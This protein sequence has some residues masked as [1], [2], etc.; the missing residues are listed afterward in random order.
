MRRALPGLSLVVASAALIAAQA[1]APAKTENFVALFN[2]ATAAYNARDYR[3]MQ[4]RL[5]EALA[6]R[7]AHPTALYNLASAQ[8]LGG[9]AA[10]ALDTLGALANMGLTFDPTRDADFKAL[11]ADARFA[12]VNARF[13]RN[14]EP[15]GTA[16]ALFRVFT[17]TFIPEGIA[18]DSD[19]GA[20]FLG[21]AHER[22]IVRIPRG[23]QDSQDFVTPGAGGLWAPLGMQADP[24]RRLLW[25]ATASIPEMSNAD[26]GEL[27]RS[28]VLAYDL[29]SGLLKRRH[30][31]PADGAE[32]LLGDLEVLRN[33]TI[34][35]TDSKAG[36]LYALD[37]TSGKFTAL[38]TPGQLAS[39]QGL[40]ISR[41]RKTLYVAD[42]TQGLYAW[43]IGKKQLSRLDVGAGISVYGIDGLYWYENSL[44]AVQNGI[45]PHRVARFKLDPSGRRVLHARVLAAN[46]PEFDEPTLGVVVGNRFS[47]V[48]NSQWNR[49]DK[50]YKLPP[51]EQLRSPV[52]LRILLD[53]A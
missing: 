45:R 16:T 24:E 44:V 43:D 18:Y 26:P 20:Y 48:A 31:L 28:A 5:G 21:G 7:P 46:L 3:T 2:A 6:L 10:A 32:H 30:V 15:A 52:V 50:N 25:V 53:G 23:G 40:A 11:S 17:P 39:P 22:E 9:N 38:T 41:D 34:Y 29:D 49:F 36:V 47:F 19:T 1:A 33:G 51:K 13:A 42:Y 4:A 12:E 14:R 37:S 8:A 35:T 27:G